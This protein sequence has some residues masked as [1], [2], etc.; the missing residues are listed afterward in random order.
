[1]CGTSAV[2]CDDGNA[3]TDDSCDFVLGCQHTPT[4]CDDS[5]ACTVDSCDPDAGCQNEPVDCDDGNPCTDNSCD[6]TFGCQTV[7]NTADCVTEDG[8]EGTCAAGAC[9]ANCPPGQT[10]CGDMCTDTSVDLANCGACGNACTTDV[11]NST[12]VCSGGACGYVCNACDPNFTSDPVTCAC[13]CAIEATDCPE[14]YLFDEEA[15]A[16]YAPFCPAGT[17]FGAQCGTGCFCEITVEGPVLCF[18]GVGFVS[19]EDTACTT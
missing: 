10:T 13:V 6:T 9:V 15:C 4:N 12:A 8:E 1:M 7:N 3:C 5:N 18:T 11:D 16:C 2:V 17:P 14:R 19:C